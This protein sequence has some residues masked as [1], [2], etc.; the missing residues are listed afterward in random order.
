MLGL[1]GFD[2]AGLDPVEPTGGG[3]GTE[4]LGTEGDEG[5]PGRPTPPPPHA[6]ARLAAIRPPPRT[7]RTAADKRWMVLCKIA[8]KPLRSATEL[9]VLRLVQTITRLRT[10]RNLTLIIALV[11]VSPRLLRAHSAGVVAA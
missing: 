6:H 9:V 4:G 3:L 2:G 1:A 8:P 11:P 7:A 10:H 5:V